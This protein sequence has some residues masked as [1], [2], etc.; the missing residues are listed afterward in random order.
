MQNT[1]KK[2][3]LVYLILVC[4]ISLNAQ[5]DSAL[6]ADYKRNIIQIEKLKSELETEKQNSLI[7]KDD[8]SKQIKESQLTINNLKDQIESL[9]GDLVS[10]K[11]KIADLNKNKIKIERDILQSK[12]DSLNSRIIELNLEISE[13]ENKLISQKSS[14]KLEVEKAMEEGKNEVLNSISKFYSSKSF[15]ELINLSN[16]EIILRDSKI[17]IMEIKIVSIIDDLKAYYLALEVLSSKFDAEKIKS[18]QESL[19]KIARDSK[20]IK[21]LL[22]D[23]AKYSDYNAYL[24]ETIVK[25]IDFDSKKEAGTEA[26]IQKLKFNDIMIYLSDFIYNYDDYT[27]YPYLSS[28]VNEI[29]SRKK[30]NADKSITDLLQKL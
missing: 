6:I 10:E 9:K 16:K 18:S 12:I 2:L 22:D 19:A 25:L 4:G 14:S 29:I 23:L 5:S 26:S 28:V 20:P 13:G 15:D 17:L 24:K 11:K 27:K 30:D 21:Q 1:M 7:L 8:H 3:L